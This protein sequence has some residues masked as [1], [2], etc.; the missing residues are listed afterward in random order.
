MADFDLNSILNSL[1]PEDMDNIKSLASEFLGN[2]G[3]DQPTGAENN[4]TEKPPKLPDIN[5]LP[6][7]GL[8]DLSVLTSIAPVLQAVNKPDD[9]VQFINAMKPLLSQGRRQKADE[10]INLLRLIS[11]IPLLREGGII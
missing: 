3:N 10:A 5:S 2:T 8:P 4:A 11:V 6:L 9:R 1:S 7:G